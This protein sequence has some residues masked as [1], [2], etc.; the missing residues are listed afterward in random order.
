MQELRN[1]EKGPPLPQEIDGIEMEIAGPDPEGDEPGAAP[2]EAEEGGDFLD[3]EQRA[4][5][6]GFEHRSAP[7]RK[8]PPPG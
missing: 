2:V 5:Q 7:T 6:V 8:G 4:R 3:A 1:Q